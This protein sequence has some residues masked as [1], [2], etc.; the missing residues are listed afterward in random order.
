[1][2]VAELRKALERLPD[3]T[4]FTVECDGFIMQ[5]KEI[6]VTGVELAPTSPGVISYKVWAANPRVL[7]RKSP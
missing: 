5:I 4:E 7:V 2:T 6:R 3:D 1:M